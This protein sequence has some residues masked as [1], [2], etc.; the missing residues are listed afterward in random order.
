MSHGSAKTFTFVRGLRGTNETNVVIR[1]GACCGI[2][3]ERGLG[4]PGLSQRRGLGAVNLPDSAVLVERT[5]NHILGGTID[6]MYREFG[7]EARQE[8]RKKNIFSLSDCLHCA[9]TEKGLKRGDL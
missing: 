2:G 6:W 8:R 1:E 9:Y 7:F 5:H 3:N 4:V